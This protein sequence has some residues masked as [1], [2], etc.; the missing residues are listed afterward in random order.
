MRSPSALN[1]YMLATSTVTLT[2]CPTSHPRGESRRMTMSARRCSPGWRWCAGAGSLAGPERRVR[3]GPSLDRIPPTSPGEAAA[4]P[5][6][7]GRRDR[8]L[9][10]SMSTRRTPTFQPGQ[11]LVPVIFER[12]NPAL[13]HRPG[14]GLP[15]LGE[16]VRPDPDQHGQALI[17]GEDLGPRVERGSRPA[18][19]STAAAAAGIRN[20]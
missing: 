16:H 10:V 4:R 7:A 12:V 11:P 17:L 5:G 1:K 20:R 9:T 2:T 18:G 14:R 19:R 3:P 13:Q 8:A 6:L 15:G